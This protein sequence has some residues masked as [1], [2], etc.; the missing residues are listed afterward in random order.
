M[1]I[2]ELE[3]VVTMDL[4]QEDKQNEIFCRRALSIQKQNI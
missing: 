1:Y 3:I 2:E 4:K